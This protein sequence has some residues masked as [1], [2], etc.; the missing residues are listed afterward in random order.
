ME[1]GLSIARF[2]GRRNFLASRDGRF[3]VLY[4][5]ADQRD[6]AMDLAKSH[7]VEV[8]PWMTAPL[9]GGRAP[10]C[11]LCGEDGPDAGCWGVAL[12]HGYF[13][14]CGCHNCA[15]RYVQENP[16]ACRCDVKTATPCPHHD[17]IA[18]VPY[19]V[20]AV[21][22][23]SLRVRWVEEASVADD[24]LAEVMLPSMQVAVHGWM[25]PDCRPGCV[26]T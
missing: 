18:G 17:A 2:V 19:T 4:L 14:G 8:Q 5:Y 12:C 7:G 15:L 10:G 23:T 1:P 25:H 3:L 24:V 22:L 26:E 9:W 6:H 13:N 21:W 16:D 20:A 11:S